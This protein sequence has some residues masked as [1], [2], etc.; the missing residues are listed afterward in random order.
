MVWSK[1]GEMWSQQRLDPHDYLERVFLSLK[2]KLR[3]LNLPFLEY[4]THERKDSYQR[5]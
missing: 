5:L 1:E 3:V 2:R 4:G